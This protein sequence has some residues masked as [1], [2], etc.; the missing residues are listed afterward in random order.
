MEAK[1]LSTESEMNTLNYRG[2]TVWNSLT[3]DVKNASNKEVFKRLLTK[4]GD[5]VEQ[6][7]FGKGTV[8]L[9]NKDFEALIYF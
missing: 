2:T 8:T 9:K 5:S 3:T 7:T 4:E 6:I 1:R